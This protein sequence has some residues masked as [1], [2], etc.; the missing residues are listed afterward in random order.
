L[1]I[2][3]SQK[4]LKHLSEL[5]EKKSSIANERINYENIEFNIIKKKKKA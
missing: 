5:Q 3:Q 1:F 2:P 4:L